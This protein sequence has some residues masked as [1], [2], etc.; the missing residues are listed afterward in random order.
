MKAAFGRII[1]LVLAAWLLLACESDSKDTTTESSCGFGETNQ[2]D[3]CLPDRDGDGVPDATDNCPSLSNSDQSDSDNDGYGD[4]CDEVHPG[5]G[6]DGDITTDDDDDMMP[7]GDEPDGDDLD[8]DI[9]TDDDDD[10]LDGDSSEEDEEDESDGDELDGD[11]PDGDEDDLPSGSG[12]ADDPFIIPGDPTLPDYHDSQ[13]TT[14]ATSDEFD[15][16]PGWD[17]LDES[18]PEYVYQL[19]V[20]HT[21]KI[22]A[23]LAFPEPDGVD[24]DI[25]LLDSLNPLSLIARGHYEVES[26]VEAGTYYLILDTY[27]SDGVEHAGHYDLTVELTRVASGTEDDL[28]VLNEDLSQP[29]ALPFFY[30]DSRDTTNAT[31]D[32]FDSYPGWDHLDESGPEYIYA[33]RLD[34]EA[35]VQIYIDNPEPDGVDIDLHLLSSLSPLTLVERDHTN[36]LLTLQAG[37]YYIVMDTYVSDGVEKAGPYHLRVLARQPGNDDAY[38]ENYILDAVEFLYTNYALL[39]YGDSVLTHD[40]EYG[41]YGIIP[42]TGGARTMCVAAVMEVILTAMQ[43][44]EA[45]TGD[46]TVW[47]FL[48]MRSW[49]Y[50]SEDDI[51]A[52]IWVN[53]SLDS[54]GTADALRHFGMGENVPFEDLT[55]GSFININRTTGTGHAVVFLAFIDEQGIQYDS[56][57]DDVIGFYYFSSQ[58][59][60][61]EGSGGL[62]F[63]YAIFQTDDYETNG[64]PSM[65]YNRDIHIIYSTSQT[66]L[67]TGRMY[68]PSQWVMMKRALPERLPDGTVPEKPQVSFF[69][70][71]YFDGVTVDDNLD[72]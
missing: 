30:E 16:Y 53:H 48:P 8:G 29:L 23:Y 68:H 3:Q 15:L 17:N 58:G 2:N 67:N 69:D 9:P 71:E 14:N 35:R 60:Y 38:F 45:D 56:Y 64:Y 41:D 65:P 33:F 59:G 44:Y 34:R 63:R 21:T 55:P 22:H 27:V 28:I 42:R 32:A 10:T 54:Y 26:V 47:D 25:H 18:G 57:N 19:T 13:D 39:G 66:Y 4:A 52:H 43:L 61:D 40:I 50:L 46:T 62:D 7:D 11:E 72:D 37:V 5:S 12:T 36:L 24:V 31:S 49:Q 1:L 6:S 51:K 70:A 20:N